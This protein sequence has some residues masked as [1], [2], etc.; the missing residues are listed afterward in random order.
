MP[1][2]AFA[3]P[4]L[5]PL[6][7]GLTRAPAPSR[8]SAAAPR[9]ASSGPKAPEGFAAPEP[10]VAYVRRDSLPRIAG[11]ALA[12]AL[13][14]GAGAT[15]SGY[16]LGMQDGKVRERSVSLPEGRPR[17]PL[18]LYAFPACPFCRKVFEALSMLDLDVLV[19]PTPK[20]GLVYRPYV[21]E[22]FGKS[23]FPYLFDPNT[24]FSGYESADIIDFLFKTYGGPDAR[25]PLG[26]L[27]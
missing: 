11:G 12:M 1:R 15:V 20:G 17:E 27:L 7:S 19:K 13:R 22:S 5:L 18:V 3:G 10:R 4:A 2:P 21:V 26:E 6:R 8:R 9:M 23:Q 16:R 25:P 14:A 24:G